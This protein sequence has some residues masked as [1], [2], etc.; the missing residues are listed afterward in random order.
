[1]RIISGSKKVGAAVLARSTCHN[2]YSP[3]G[4]AVA[5][6]RAL[7]YFARS[8]LVTAQVLPV[9]KR[10]LTTSSPVRKSLL[11]RVRGPKTFS[12]RSR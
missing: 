1:M 12:P 3:L 10:L 5:P 11:A 2:G 9:S 6:G 7:K 4:M 8:L